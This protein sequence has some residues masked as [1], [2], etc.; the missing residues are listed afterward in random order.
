MQKAVPKVA[1]VFSIVISL[2]TIPPESMNCWL[3]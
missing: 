2:R 1:P 3:T